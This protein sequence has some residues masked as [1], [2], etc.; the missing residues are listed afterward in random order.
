MRSFFFKLYNLNENLKLSSTFLLQT[1]WCANVD[2]KLVVSYKQ[3]IAYLL[4]YMM[5]EEQSS[6]AFQAVCKSLVDEVPEGSPVRKALQRVLIKTVGESDLSSQE[7]HLI[8]ANIDSVQFSK[9]FVS[10]NVMGTSRV[11][12]DSEANDNASATARNHATVYWQREE[13]EDYKAVCE[14]FDRGESEVDPRTITL[15][16]FASNYTLK[17]NRSSQTK[18]PHVVPN[19]NKVPNKNDKEQRQYKLFVRTCLLIHKAGTTLNGLDM[20]PLADQELMMEEFVATPE[21]PLVVIEEWEE[22]QASKSEDNREGREEEERGRDGEVDRGPENENNQVG[23][24]VSTPD[25]ERDLHIEPVPAPEEYN[26]PDDYMLLHGQIHIEAPEDA[27]LD[28]EEDYEMQGLNEAHADYDWSSD[29]RDLGMSS[30]DL[31]NCQTWLK[32]AISTTKLAQRH[33]GQ[34]FDPLALND[35]QFFAFAIVADYLEKVHSEL[36]PPQLLM[37]ISG[38]PGTGKTFWLNTCRAYANTLGMHPLAIQTSAPSGTA[39]FLIDGNTLHKL[40]YLPLGVGKMQD[41]AGSRLRQLQ[42]TFDHT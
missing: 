9:N 24:E 29:V 23:E 1:I 42:E 11:T 32:D 18:V 37:N 39:A 6:A 5:K 41:L 34:M 3:L 33:L 28:D 8:L 16:E 4:K 26:Q 14:K 40:L 36:Q 38:G 31:K 30:Q 2:S 25:Q 35:M 22:S 15:Y 27:L 19:F 20:L 10:V 7:C 21:C 12:A 13:S 17:W